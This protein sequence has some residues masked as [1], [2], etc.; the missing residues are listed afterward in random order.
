[1]PLLTKPLSPQERQAAA[2]RRQGM[3]NTEIG[4][5]MQIPNGQ[6]SQVICHARRKGAVV[7]YAKRDPLQLYKNT[8]VVP[9]TRLLHIRAKLLEAGNGHYGINTIIAQ[10]VGMSPGCV[11]VRLWKYDRNQ[12]GASR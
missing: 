6:V 7:P 10:R 2:L 5:I 3:S 8:K 9:I 4:E 12:Q 1:M 11:R